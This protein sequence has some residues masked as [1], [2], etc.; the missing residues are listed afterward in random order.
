MAGLIL[1][2]SHLT[3]IILILIGAFVG[4]SSTSAMVDYDKKRIRFSN[5]L[6]GIIRTGQWLFLE[7][8]MKIGMR[9]SN[10]AWRA[11]S[12][13]NRAIDSVT[14]DY[15]IILLDSE[16]KEIMQI[17]KTRTRESAIG[18]LETM[19]NKLGLKRIE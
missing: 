16:D 3:G 6:F 4:F 5:N 10:L 18:E 19:G 15:R 12:S 17:K 1:T 8:A 2:Y 11:Y 9:E 13:G 7:P 14:K